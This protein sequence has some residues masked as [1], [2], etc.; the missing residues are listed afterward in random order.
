M[1]D[2]DEG[3]R[4]PAEA[5]RHPPNGSPRID[6]PLRPPNAGQRP[7]HPQLQ[8]GRGMGARATQAGRNLPREFLGPVPV[9]VP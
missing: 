6:R 9:A 3:H 7:R 8:Q 1:A 5:K 4:L 2:L